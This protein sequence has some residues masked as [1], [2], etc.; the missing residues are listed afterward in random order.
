[1]VPLIRLPSHQARLCPFCPNYPDGTAVKVMIAEILPA[2]TG[3]ISMKR[4]ILHDHAAPCAGAAHQDA[5][6]PH[7]PHKL[8]ALLVAHALFTPGAK[9]AWQ[10]EFTR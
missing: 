9:V 7:S 6:G 2:I 1:V 10:T 5:Q 4:K 3:G 8:T